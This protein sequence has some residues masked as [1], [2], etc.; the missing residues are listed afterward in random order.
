MRIRHLLVVAALSPAAVQAQ[1]APAGYGRAR[2][3][4]TEDRPGYCPANGAGSA[5]RSPDFDR[6]VTEERDVRSG[7]D[8]SPDR[9]RCRDQ[10]TSPDLDR[11]AVRRV[12]RAMPGAY[13]VPQAA[14]DQIGESGSLGIR[15]IEIRIPEIRLAL[16]ELRLPSCYRVRRRAEM[17]VAESRAPF[18]EGQAATYGM[19]APGGLPVGEDALV[20]ETLRRRTA[21]LE[22]DRDSD[23]DVEDRDVED[24]DEDRCSPPPPYPP[25][26]RYP[27]QPIYPQ[28]PCHDAGAYG[29]PYG[30]RPMDCAPPQY[31]P[32]TPQD[33]PLP[34]SLAPQFIVPP[35]PAS[36]QDTRLERLRQ[37]M[38]VQQQVI[39]ELQK[40]MEL[41]RQGI[42]A[43]LT[44]PVKPGEWA[45]SSSLPVAARAA[46]TREQAEVRADTAPTNPAQTM[47]AGDR[48][49]I[50]WLRGGPIFTD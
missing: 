36:T 35:A 3:G 25:Q 15:G 47:A 29:G 46:T 17:E 39:A 34:P 19:T 20:M 37:Q 44:P 1:Y 32:V 13:A 33:P 41:T 48:Q 4:C 2:V 8:A 43:A 18:V 6:C 27:Q 38:A 22:R 42:D 7:G 28:V 9:D 21:P 49:R 26:Y 30:D 45:P 10:D 23:R 50:E 14:G 24:R 16:P 31:P 11:P 5:P 40:S 12:A